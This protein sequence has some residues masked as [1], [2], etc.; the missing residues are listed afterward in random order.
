MKLKLSNYMKGLL[1]INLALCLVSCKKMDATYSGYIKGGEIVY[2]SKADSVKTYPGKNRILLTWPIGTDPKVSKAIV[3]WNNREN[4]TQYIIDRKAGVDTAKLW[5]NNMSEGSYSLDIFTYDN[6]GNSSVKVNV[7]SNVYGENYNNSIVNRKV[8]TFTYQNPLLL[9]NWYNGNIGAVAVEVTYTNEQDIIKKVLT[10]IAEERTALPD[11]KK[12]T[13]ISYRTLYLPERSPL[14]T[15][16]T[17]PSVII[18][19]L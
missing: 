7:Q 18:P 19:K 16:Y 17:A 5:L 9:I 2:V 3:F 1:L 15:F 6:K 11:Y 12:T 8:K 4:S 10:Q 13:E 14:D